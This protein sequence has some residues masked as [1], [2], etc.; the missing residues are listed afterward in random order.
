[1]EAAAVPASHTFLMYNQEAQLLAARFV[2]HGTFRGAGHAPVL[3]AT[4]DESRSSGGAGGVSGNDDDERSPGMV[5]VAVDGAGAAA[6]GFPRPP[7]P[8]ALRVGAHAL[9]AGGVV[10]VPTDTLYGLACAATSKEGILRLYRI[11]GRDGGKP[12]AVC[13]GDVAQVAECGE[14]DHLPQATVM[15]GHGVE[16]S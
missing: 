12:V 3:P 1:M 14:A 16:E 10:A 5:A 4:P 6:S 2:A 11:K 7:L 15:S 9:R 13:V 8:H